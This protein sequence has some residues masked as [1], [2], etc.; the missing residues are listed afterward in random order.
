MTAFNGLN[1]NSD[2]SI[3]INWFRDSN[4]RPGETGNS[5]VMFAGNDTVM[6]SQCSDMIAGG[7]GND[8]LDG[9]LGND[10]LSGEDGKDT[11]KNNIPI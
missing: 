5:I 2:Q 6:G 11:V 4:L 3:N 8:M 7:Y 1:N 10:F 9:Y